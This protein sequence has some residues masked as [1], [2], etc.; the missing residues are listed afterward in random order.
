[1]DEIILFNEITELYLGEHRP[2]RAA[3]GARDAG[4]PHRVAASGRRG[5]GRETK[6]PF[7]WFSDKGEAEPAEELAAVAPRSSTWWPASGS[8]A[9]SRA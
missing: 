8:T 7:P 2:G 3:G 1:M 6:F 9:R 5:P 4:V